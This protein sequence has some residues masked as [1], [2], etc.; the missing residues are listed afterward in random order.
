VV[1]AGPSVRGQEPRKAPTKHPLD[2]HTHLD[3]AV[4]EGGQQ[5]LVA[6]RLAGAA[7]TS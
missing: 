1:A 5:V 3:A 6:A 2:S 4:E 7:R